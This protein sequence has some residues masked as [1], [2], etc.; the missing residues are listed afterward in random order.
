MPFDYVIGILDRDLTDILRR[1]CARSGRRH[2]GQGPVF[3]LRKDRIS[4]SVGI[5]FLAPTSRHFMAAAMEA[6]CMHS[7]MGQPWSAP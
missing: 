5:P 4:S 6:K 7:A 1:L 3:S 2:V